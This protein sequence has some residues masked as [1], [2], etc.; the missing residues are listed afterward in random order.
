MFVVTIENTVYAYQHSPLGLP[1]NNVHCVPRSMLPC[2]EGNTLT[3]PIMWRSHGD[4]WVEQPWVPHL[5][6]CRLFIVSH[7][8]LSGTQYAS[9]VASQATEEILLWWLQHTTI[10]ERVGFFRS[11]C[12]RTLSVRMKETES[13][14]QFCGRRGLHGPANN[15]RRIWRWA[16]REHPYLLQPCGDCGD[17]PNTI[18]YSVRR[19]K[20]AV[21]ALLREHAADTQ[22]VAFTLRWDELDQRL[23]WQYGSR[24][25]EVGTDTMDRLEYLV[26]RF[27]G[28]ELPPSLR[29]ARVQ[30]WSAI[31]CTVLRYNGDRF[32]TT[33]DA[34]A[35]HRT[36]IYWLCV[37]CQ[38]C[39]HRMVFVDCELSS[40]YALFGNLRCDAE[41]DHTIWLADT[42]VSAMHLAD[43]LGGGMHVDTV[44]NFVR[45]DVSPNV[46]NAGTTDDD[47]TVVI[48]EQCALIVVGMHH[49]GIS[50]QIALLHT[51]ATATIPRCVQLSVFLVGD[52]FMRSL[53]T[54]GLD[55]WSC[56]CMATHNTIP[57]D[58]NEV[59]PDARKTR[60]ALSVWV[61]AV[62]SRHPAPPLPL[63]TATDITT[64]EGWRWLVVP[65]L[66]GR[67]QLATWFAQNV[68][69][70]MPSDAVV[71]T[72][73]HCD[74]LTMVTA[75]AA[76][77]TTG[78]PP[79]PP[80]R[81]RSSPR[82]GQFIRCVHNSLVLTF[83]MVYR[84]LSHD[85]PRGVVELEP[86]TEP[87]PIVVS[88]AEV[89]SSCEMAWIGLLQHN[90]NTYF[91][92]RPLF[93]LLANRRPVCWPH[94][95]PLLLAQ[96]AGRNVVLV[97]THNTMRAAASSLQSALAARPSTIPPSM[98]QDLIGFLTNKYADDKLE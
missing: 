73:Q 84:I 57:M 85:P 32:L 63:P 66:K 5:W 83:G 9:I 56:C 4:G 43:G 44:S 3:T 75:S 17:A 33:P 31:G 28:C 92:D 97:A 22:Q 41:W 14:P 98:W 69:D 51:I 8:L 89:Q 65:D 49:L 96:Q 76:T 54:D 19:T 39:S 71:L 74:C 53:G 48:T 40:Q 11:P 20:K 90:L 24:L 30:R 58:A 60:R 70:R 77:V 95:N 18:A 16:Q 6:W 2:L 34:D 61:Q 35:A 86:R 15:L 38:Q 10:A 94:P 52:A 1:T 93:V 46:F 47:A 72:S 45:K 29:H 82:T 21:M 88:V 68:L 37:A 87:T 36:F 78:P 80:L 79:L 50:Q 81:D 13:Q 67:Q 62:A 27:A 64:S 7:H 42:T 59:G 23:L 26:P 91:G 55:P 25:A 12:L